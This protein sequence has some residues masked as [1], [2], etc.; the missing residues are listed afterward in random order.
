MQD[1]ADHALASSSRPGR[2]RGGGGGG[3]VCGLACVL[4]FAPE[5]PTKLK[6]IVVIPKP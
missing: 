1:V 5:P 2:G 6:K 3:G 4:L